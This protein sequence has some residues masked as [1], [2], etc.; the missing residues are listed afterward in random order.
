MIKQLFKNGIKNKSQLFVGLMGTI[1][2]FSIFVKFNQFTNL[3]PA[4]DWTDDFIPGFFYTIIGVS[5]VLDALTEFG[6]IIVRYVLV[7]SNS[8]MFSLLTISYIVDGQFSHHTSLY[9]YIY[10]T[11]FLLNLVL[12]YELPG[13]KEEKGRHG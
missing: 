4:L 10:G 1:V 11:I 13:L 7:I 12:A 3:P 9:P 8:M 2:G 5:T 6:D